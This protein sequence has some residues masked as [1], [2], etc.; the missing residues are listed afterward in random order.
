M[1]QQLSKAALAGVIVLVSIVSALAQ[2]DKKCGGT[3]YTGKDVSERA[4]IT[5]PA[6]LGMVYKAFGSD[7]QGHAVVDAVLCRSGQVT[8][9]AAVDVSPLKIT[10]FVVD[11]VSLIEFK[12]AERN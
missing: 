10:Q 5:K 11:A 2:S 7:I 3:I 9:I 12:P 8:D 1:I 4:K 6:D